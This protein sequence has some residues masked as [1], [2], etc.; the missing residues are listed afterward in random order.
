MTFGSNELRA[1]SIFCRDRLF[2]ISANPLTME[3]R[4]A[5]RGDAASISLRVVL[6]V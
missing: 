5:L 6:N 1:A 4:L 2:G 3:E